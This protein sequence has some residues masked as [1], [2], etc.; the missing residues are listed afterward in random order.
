MVAPPVI[1]NPARRL[2]A[3]RRMRLHQQRPDAARFLLDHLADDLLERLAFLRAAPTRALVIGETTGRV[4]EALEAGGS[5][6]LRADLTPRPGEQAI[7]EERPFPDDGFDL[8]AGIGLLDTVNDLPG[9]LIHLRNALAPGGMV[10]A[11]F[12][13]AGSL[14]ALR[15]AM[16]A[17]DA[18]RPAARLYPMVDV[19]AAAEL[20]QRAGWADPVVDGHGL[21]VR[22]SSLERLVRDLREQGLG[23]VLA[24]R[25]P[26]LDRAAYRRAEQAFAGR[27]DEEGKVVERFEFVTLSG[28]RTRR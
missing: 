3:R 6:V 15:H 24:S 7:E 10:F 19:R 20:V 4:A 18:D 14:P 12:M 23:N 28:R 5:S 16:L 21:D 2:A 1:F 26:V 9:A 13:G 17:A 22:Y 8:V 27:A 25:A 11:S